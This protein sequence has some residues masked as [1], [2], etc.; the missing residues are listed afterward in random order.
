MIHEVDEVLKGLLSGGAL[1]ARA[2][3]SPSTPRPGTGPPA[4]T[5]PRSTPTS[6]TS[7]R[8][9][10][11]ASGAAPGPG[12][13]GHHR[14]APSAAALVPAVVPGDGLDEAAPGRAPAAVRRA[15]HTHPARA[16]A[17][18][19]TPGITGRVGHDDPRVGG[20]YPD[21]VALPRGDLVRTR[22]RT[23]AVPGPGDHRALPG[24]PR[25]RRRAARH[26][27]RRSADELPGRYA[28]HGGTRAQPRQVAAAEEAR[29]RARRIAGPGRKPAP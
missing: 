10:T 22:R 3:T 9:S 11:A 14:Q 8:T 1:A 19:R 5:R 27:G 23:Q 24:L 25:V 7:V 18:L 28:R 2:S 15:G 17:A 4:A 6:T 16:A 13:P 21:R 26:R 29:R 20:R 12:R